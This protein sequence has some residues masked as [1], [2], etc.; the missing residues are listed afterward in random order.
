MFVPLN[1]EVLVWACLVPSR[2]CIILL[3][4]SLAY[5]VGTVCATC[6]HPSP[7]TAA[8]E[9]NSFIFMY[10]LDSMIDERIVVI[11]RQ[12]SRLA[13]TTGLTQKEDSTLTG[14]EP[15]PIL[16]RDKGC[17]AGPSGE[18]EPTRKKSEIV[19]RSERL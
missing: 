10:P 3:L 5:R 7:Y 13:Q 17:K 16:T 9:I 4:A 14:S 18:L 11:S 12:G 15:G 8:S 2:V 19:S 1:M 6:A